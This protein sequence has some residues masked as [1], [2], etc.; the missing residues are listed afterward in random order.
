[1][2]LKIATLCGLAQLVESIYG[3]N[4]EK[5]KIKYITTNRFGEKCTKT[6][7]VDDLLQITPEQDCDIAIVEYDLDKQLFVLEY[8]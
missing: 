8:K 3:N 7:E 4:A 6:F 1:M 2:L 5:V